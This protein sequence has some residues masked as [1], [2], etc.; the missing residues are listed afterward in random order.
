MPDLK[1]LHKPI[2]AIT[3][4]LTFL[5]SVL[6]F[7]H[8]PALYPD[9]AYGFQVLRNMRMG[10]EFNILPRPDQEDISKS[11]HYF[12]AW[13]SP[14]QYLV[15]YLFI[16][17][18]GLN[19]GRAVAVTVALGSFIGLWGFYRLFKKL[20][21]TPL[22]AAFSIFFI[23]CQ[24][25]YV[26]PYVFYN[27]GEILI[28][29]FTGW[30]L[31]GCT[32]INKINW[33]FGVFILFSGLIGFFCKSAFIWLYGAGLIYLWIRLSNGK[34]LTR[35][36]LN[37]IAMAVPSILS[38]AIIYFG[39][40]SKGETPTS[41]AAGLKVTLEAFA[42]PIASPLLAGFSIDDLT[43]GLIFHA[44]KPIFNPQ[45]T[46]IILLLLA[47]GSL[48]LFIGILKKVRHK[49]YQLLLGILYAVAFLFFCCQ[50]LLQA[51][52]SYEARHFRILGIMIIPGIFS[53]L[54]K[55]PINGQAAFGVVWLLI[56]GTT[57]YFFGKG[58]H[59][60]AFETAHGSTGVAHLFIDQTTLNYI[61]RLDEQHTNARFVFVSPDIGL[62][63]KHNHIISLNPIGNDLVIDH[64]YYD[65]S[66]HPGPLFMVLPASYMGTKA[67]ELMGA[68][69]D[70]QNFT[71]I[72]PGKSSVIY[73]AE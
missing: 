3:A 12:L 64:D 22:Q 7:I 40:L 72:M 44:D 48:A 58:Y 39:Y 20:G 73:Q 29:A 30:F 1:S 59:R 71:I 19:I 56:A 51:D 41:A 23:A 49:N 16:K 70:Y 47:V 69:V 43:N 36:L 18:F 54:G 55:A 60:N 31:L 61:T 37:G 67:N 34:N 38:L 13:W 46:V 9:T 6:T 50:F 45:L 42:F 25:F 10:G 14:G 17:L 57:V 52:I 63:I 65:H 8:P 32:A 2:L 4:L 28:F 62:E 68:F 26:I 33:Q 5:I 11:L 24:Q 66:G 27:G 35:W 15:P 21:F 53:L